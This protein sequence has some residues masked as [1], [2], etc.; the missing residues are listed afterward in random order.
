MGGQILLP[1]TSPGCSIKALPLWVKTRLSSRAI[2]A[3][4]LTWCNHV[5]VQLLPL[6]NLL[7]F[8]SSYC[9][10]A[11]IPITSYTQISD[12]RVCL[13]GMWFK[14]LHAWTLAGDGW[15][16]GSNEPMSLFMSSQDLSMKVLWEDSQISSL[17]TQ[18]FERPRQ[19][20]L[21]S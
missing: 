16:L 10:W 2:L 9:S 3:S 15:T 18:G 20:Q 13:L 19:K 5:T 4:K 17:M 12:L 11:N 8:I 7:M 6:P 1:M 14:K 21:F